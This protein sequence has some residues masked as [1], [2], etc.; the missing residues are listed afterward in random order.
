[1]EN[2]KK[3]VSHECPISLLHLSL[4]WN[5]YDYCLVHLLE[6]YPEYRKFFERSLNEENRVV[7]LDNSIFE[8]GQAFQIDKFAYWI[9]E[10][11]PTYYIIPD[12]LEDYKG[13]IR[14]LR[15][16]MGKYNGLPG[17]KIGVVQGRTYEELVAC[18]V[19]VD[20]YA[21]VI[22]IS[23]DYSFYQEVAPSYSRWVSYMLGR[24]MFLNRLINDKVINYLKPHH[25]LGC[26][27]PQEFIYYNHRAYR[28][29]TSID[30]SSPV[31]N[32][33]KNIRYEEYGLFDKPTIKLAELIETPMEDIQLGV[34]YQN[35]FQFKKFV[36]GWVK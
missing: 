1:M 2:L 18:Y 7:I 3:L 29:I 25:L 22:A 36:N 8:L 9:R 19:E 32:A 11:E 13:T 28:F 6:D 15:Q 26:S 30:T 12:V 20:K 27:L 5:D 4:R 34:L 23:F 16:W 33:I 10:L 21:D 24:A 35:L 14:N 31:V 17:K